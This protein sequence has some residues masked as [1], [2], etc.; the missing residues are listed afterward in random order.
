MRIAFL[1]AAI[2][3]WLAAS[4]SPATA[5]SGAWERQL[6][7]P[8]GDVSD[9]AFA[10]QSVAWYVGPGGVFRTQD[11]GRSWA[12]ASTDVGPLYKT[13]AAPDG[14]H[15]WAVGV[16]GNIAATDDGGRTWRKQSSG[17][18]VN[19]GSITAV[20]DKTAIA[21]GWGV[22]FSDVI[23]EPQPY[24]L[25]RTTDGGATWRSFTVSGGYR[26]QAMAA[27]GD[28]E[29]AW[30]AGRRC[31]PPAAD[32]P[33][34]G[35]SCRYE[36]ALLRTDDGGQSWSV[37]NT[38]NGFLRIQFVDARVGW[39]LLY[40][41]DAQFACT[42]GVAR[43]TDGGATWKTVKAP[44]TPSTFTISFVSLNAFDAKAAIAYE[45]G[46]PANVCVTSAS[47]TSDGGGTWRDADP[48][49][50]PGLF[51]GAVAFFDQTHGI[52][53]VGAPQWTADG[54]TW[55]DAG[56]PVVL[57][58]GDFDFVDPMTGW[59]AASKLLR[60]R[61]GGATWAPVSDKKF[62]SIDFATPSVGLGVEFSCSPAGCPGMV[63]RTTDGGATW[64]DPFPLGEVGSTPG[65]VFV[66]ER[67]GWVLDA[68]DGK[69]FHTTDSG[70]SWREQSLPVNGMSG[71]GPEIAFVDAH[72]GWVAAQSCG[73]GFSNC[74]ISMWRS[75]D[76]GDTY[77]PLASIPDEGGCGPGGLTAIDADHAWIVGLQCRELGSPFVSL[78]SDGGATWRSYSVG[79]VGQFR[80]PIFFDALTGRSIGTVCADAVAI[81]CAGTLFRTSDGGMTW[82]QEPT[83]IAAAF[84]GGTFQFVTPELAWRVTG[85]QAGFVGPSR[86]DL[87]RYDSKRP[88]IL[89]QQPEPQRAIMAPDAGT[90]GAA[91]AASGGF[92]PLAPWLFAAGAAALVVGGALRGRRVR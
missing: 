13:A 49:V 37:V 28:G 41:C 63:W 47:T 88:V 31:A 74:Q 8:A 23:I 73:P 76:G 27:I 86:H 89:N 57:G 9:I 45:Q 42:Q 78:T 29:H 1:L 83:G 72:T 38:G 59:L 44:S 16:N 24:V 55:H 35:P 18:D 22:G 70:V 7:L 48:G 32:A 21:G 90:G 43:T 3:S 19:L 71:N 39:G 36:D 30:V 68:Y 12:I 80:T 20:D 51:V 40:N 54:V 79:Y 75:D 91:R 50:T 53:A 60:T 25:L 15:G 17:T 6:S 69:S 62:S 65:V 33:L 56:M 2:V 64:T 11:G 81:G 4:A 26:P 85:Q 87:Y 84:G 77:M 92:A 5:I 34:N 10:T 67:S 82:S 46:C 66:D 61:D 52:R 14:L 58:S